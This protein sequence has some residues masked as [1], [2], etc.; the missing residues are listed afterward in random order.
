MTKHL[1]LKESLTNAPVLSFFNINNPTRLCTDASHQGLGFILRQ[2]DNSG[3]WRLIQVGSRFLTDAESC[4]A[5]IE[6]EILA[7]AW[8]TSKCHLFLAGLQHYQVI[9]DHNPLVP[10]LN[11]HQ[12]DEIENWTMVI[13]SR[14]K[15][16]VKAC[17]CFAAA[18]LLSPERLIYDSH[19]ACQAENSKPRSICKSSLRISPWQN[20]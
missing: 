2:P 1:K 5:I 19:C 13:V 18:S 8:A 12:L 11:H 3:T 6:L 16:S 10:I 20:T 14:E 9:T 4:Y 7:V 15:H 17:T